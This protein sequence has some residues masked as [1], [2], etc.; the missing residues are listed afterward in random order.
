[1]TPD[2]VSLDDLGR[3]LAGSVHEPPTQAR[4]LFH[5]LGRHA[6]DHRQRSCS[7]RNSFVVKLIAHQTA[8]GWHKGARPA[9]ARSV[10]QHQRIAAQNMRPGIRLDA[11]EVL[12]S[13]LFPKC[14]SHYHLN[15]ILNG[16]LPQVE[17]FVV[18]VLWKVGVSNL[19]EWFGPITS[20]DEDS[21]EK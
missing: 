2:A 17:Q 15:H 12:E 14:Q 8:D 6:D 1:M 19:L 11:V 13:G 20:V 18:H 3:L 16:S 7:V 21:I 10:D 9:R 5:L 4:H